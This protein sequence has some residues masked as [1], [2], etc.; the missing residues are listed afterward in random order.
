MIFLIFFIENNF[1]DMSLKS[2]QFWNINYTNNSVETTIQARR[3]VGFLTDLKTW[4]T[5]LRSKLPSVQNEE[6]NLK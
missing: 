6:E 4:L 1:I 2:L 3:D 5:F